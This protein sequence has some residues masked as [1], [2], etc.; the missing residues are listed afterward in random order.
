MRKRQHETATVLAGMLL[1][2]LTVFILIA[3]GPY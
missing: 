1:L 2:Y 3:G